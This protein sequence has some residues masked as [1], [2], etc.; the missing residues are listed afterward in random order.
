MNDPAGFTR[1]PPT[2]AVIDVDPLA[3]MF[4]N[5]VWGQVR[6]TCSSPRTRSP[7]SS[8]RRCTRSG[9]CEGRRDRSHRTGLHR[10]RS[11]SP[12]VAAF[13]QPVVGHFTGQ[14]L[15]E[16]QPTKIAAIELAT[17]DRGP[18]PAHDRR[19]VD[20]RREALRHRDS[21][22]SVRSRS[23]HRSTRSFRR[24]TD[25]PEDELP[26]INVIHI[27]FQTMVGAGTAMIGIAAWFWWRRRRVGDDVFTEKWTMRSIVVG[28]GLA[29]LALEA[30]WTTTEVGRQPWIVY[31]ESC[32]ST[33]RSRRTAGSGSAS[34]RSSSSTR[35]WRYLAARVIRGM[36][37]RWRET[38]D[39][40]LPTPYGPA[41]ARPTP[42]PS[43][44][45]V[46]RTDDGPQRR[47][48]RADVPR[49]RRVRPV[50][51]RR[52]RHRRLGPHRRRT[53]NRAANSG[54]RSTAASARSGRPTTCG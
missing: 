20:R 54:R 45:R 7:A 16:D 3:A 10:R 11:R 28:G 34:P 30:G 37:R 5:A 22:G 36:A 25:F 50:R 18:R 33:T 49:R 40:D 53:P 9:C 4:N 14:R 44:C 52:L 48:R 12:T 21:R 17:V 31:G 39:V 27:A 47:H 41:R 19:A 46:D 1:D 6:S 13:V 35:R 24:S 2:G 29:V 32:A 15:A 38:D 42:S 8:S 26:P 23:G 43:P 51:R